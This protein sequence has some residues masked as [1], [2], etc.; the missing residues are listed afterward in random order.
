MNDWLSDEQSE[1]VG[2]RVAELTQSTNSF[3]RAIESINF[4]TSDDVTAILERAAL[5]SAFTEGQ[6]D[7]A[8]LTA[9]LDQAAPGS[10]PIRNAISSSSSRNSRA[11]GAAAGA[12]AGLALAA[13]LGLARR[14]VRD[15]EDLRRIV[16]P[17]PVFITNANA[18]PSDTAALVT[19]VVAQ[20]GRKLRSRT[21]LA[22]VGES[23]ADLYESMLRTSS[24]LGLGLQR[25]DGDSAAADDQ[26]L[27]LVAATA[28]WA[29]ILEAM[30]HS[31]FVMVVDSGDSI[32]D[33][34]KQMQLFRTSRLPLV[35]C[36]LVS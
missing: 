12:L 36:V 29:A 30:A 14:R 33:V 3:A 13:G 7:L 17:L 28:G 4:T 15:A 32:N 27:T 22:A 1:I 18:S 19:G 16:D 11:L 26:T 21:S 23:T 6:R 2:Q 24:E 25:A 34:A 10:A 8:Q 20:S 35:G 5:I 31:S 9:A